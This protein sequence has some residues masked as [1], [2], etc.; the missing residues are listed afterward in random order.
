MDDNEPTNV[1]ITAL[2]DPGID[3][4]SQQQQGTYYHRLC[5]TNVYIWALYRGKRT[6]EGP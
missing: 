1:Y 4:N 5:L 2:N 6:G 3:L